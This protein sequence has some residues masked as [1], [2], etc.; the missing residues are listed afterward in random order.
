MDSV[1]FQLRQR[2][3][4][5]GVLTG[6]LH[7]DRRDVVLQWMRETRFFPRTQKVGEVRIPAADLAGAE[8]RT[9]WF[10][11]PRI[12]LRPRALDRAGL[13]PGLH[14]PGV[15]EL[16]LDRDDLPAARSVVSLINMRASEALLDRVPD[17]LDR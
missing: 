6:T 13:V 10:R 8:I 7:L 11:K 1:A 16:W 9:S 4:E 15:V 17:P 5:P 12:L 2:G 3:D 14:P